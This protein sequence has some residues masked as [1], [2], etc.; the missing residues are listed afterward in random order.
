MKIIIP[1]F[2][3]A[4]FG[5]TDIASSQSGGSVICNQNVRCPA[6]YVCDANN[7][8]CVT[9]ID[10]SLVPDAST[11]PDSTLPEPDATVSD[12]AFDDTDGDGVADQADN[13]VDTENED[14]TD[15][16][17]D[18]LGDACDPRPNHADFNLN[19][20]FLLFGGLLVDDAHTLNGG[21]RSTHGVIS[22][23]D[24]RLRGGFNP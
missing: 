22:D 9:A 10:A 13:C 19:G 5:C 8:R 15:S 16:D 2:V 7:N 11:L 12:A 3:L 4:L 1:L 6:G 24:L 18:G 14:Q 20:H 21:G 23:G 17:S